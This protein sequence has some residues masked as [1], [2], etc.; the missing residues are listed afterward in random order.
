MGS[1]HASLAASR[2]ALFYVNVD[3]FFSCMI[4]VVLNTQLR[5]SQLFAGRVHRLGDHE[6]F[7][8][9]LA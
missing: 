9:D 4:Y 6:I 2:R 7:G 1:D 8:G 3:V 5:C